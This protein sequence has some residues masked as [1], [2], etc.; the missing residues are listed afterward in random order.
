[1]RYS[2]IIYNDTCNGYGMRM[3]YFCQGCSIHCKN[4]FNKE[5]QNFN[6]GKEFTE[7]ILEDSFEVFDM[8]KNNYD[9]ITL[10]GGE[11][12]DNIEFAHYIASEFKNRFPNKTIWIYSGYTYEEIISDENRLKLLKL[13]DVLVDGRFVEELKN[14]LLKFRGSSNQRL[15][16][17]KE[18][19][20]KGE[21]ISWGN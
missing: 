10:I 7:E 15:I 5:L 13:C 17:I 4:C 14:P 11:C 21:I 2:T 12:M 20:G 8:F 16:D 1:M 18:S 19:L 6:G 9:G 3:S